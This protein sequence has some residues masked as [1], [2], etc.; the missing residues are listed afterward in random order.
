MK[1]YNCR[2]RHG[3]RLNIGDNWSKKIQANSL[4]EAYEKFIEEVGSYPE[5][6]FVEASWFGPCG[7]FD[8]HIEAAN[9]QLIENIK[10]E[11]GQSKTSESGTT[12]NN[13]NL[14]I[15]DQLLQKIIHNQNKQTEVLN[16][17]RWAIIGLG[18]FIIV[19]TM[20]LK[21]KWGL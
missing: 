1:N 16:K 18:F 8:D 6:V 17:I 5:S 2:Y 15:Q 4:N 13:K 9:Q 11:V 3:D 21:V 19:T 12:K 10:T 20:M 7:Q 14:T